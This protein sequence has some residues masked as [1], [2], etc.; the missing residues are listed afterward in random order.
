[1]IKREAEKVEVSKRGK[2]SSTTNPNDVYRLKNKN[3]HE[4]SPK[5][6]KALPESLATQLKAAEG[7]DDI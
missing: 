6:K 5:A 2:S 3:P 7:T 4:S 1:M